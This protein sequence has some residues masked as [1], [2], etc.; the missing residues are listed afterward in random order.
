[1]AGGGPEGL[2]AEFDPLIAAAKKKYMLS[3]EDL[4]AGL[5]DAVLS[6]KR[7]SKDRS[8]FNYTVALF[9]LKKFRAV[10][11]ASVGAELFAANFD[12]MEANVYARMNDLHTSTQPEWAKVLGMMSAMT[13]SV[14]PEA[15][16][17][18]VKGV[19]YAFTTVKGVDCIEIVM[20]SSYLKYRTYMRQSSSTPLFQ[21]DQPFLH[22]IKDATGLVSYGTSQELAKPGVYTFSC[23]DLHKMGVEEFK[24]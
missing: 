21:G 1:M 3:E 18:L 7:N 12:E 17:S 22:S 4:T 6:E 13:Y 9:G 20:R 24:S 14:P 10:V 23:S 19:D 15:A 5:D 16:H 8:V 11:E 2:R